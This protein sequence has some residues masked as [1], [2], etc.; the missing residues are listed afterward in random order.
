VRYRARPSFTVEVKRNNK[1]LPLTVTEGDSAPRE[2]YRRADQLLFGGSSPT[3]NSAAR[4]DDGGL[5]TR[6][7]DS[8]RQPPAAEAV[9]SEPQAEAAVAQRLTGRILPD[10]FGETRADARLRQEEEER[11]ARLRAQRGARKTSLS[12]EPTRADTQTG[13]EPDAG[14][15]TDL[16]SIPAAEPLSLDEPVLAA[17]EVGGS[18][19]AEPVPALIP[20]PLDG[21]P[22]RTGSP[23][24]GRERKASRAG[25]RGGERQSASTGLRAGEK[26]KRRLPRVCW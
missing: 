23:R 13:D 8:A 25:G 14:R 22:E 5:S 21:P 2:R 11:A 3:V 15:T 16:A 17:R 19:A 26:W 9:R 18:A 24:G 12:L 20:S 7:T 10:L 1:R 6:T 4:L